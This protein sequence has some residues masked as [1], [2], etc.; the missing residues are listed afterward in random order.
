MPSTAAN[1]G[2]QIHRRDI[3]TRT[4]TPAGPTFTI[5]PIKRRERNNFSNRLCWL[6][7]KAPPF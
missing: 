3:A 6:R 1:A 7:L 4:L 2:E 5:V